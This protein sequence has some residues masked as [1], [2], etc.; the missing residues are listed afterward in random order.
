VTSHLGNPTTTLRLFIIS[1]TLSSPV[2]RERSMVAFY[3]SRTYKKF[4]AYELPY[5]IHYEIRGYE[6]YWQC[7]PLM[8]M[9]NWHRPCPLHASFIKRWKAMNIR[10]PFL[11]SQRNMARRSCVNFLRS[12]MR[13]CQDDVNFT[14]KP[15]FQGKHFRKPVNK[16]LQK[17]NAHSLFYQFFTFSTCHFWKDLLL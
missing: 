13:E 9:E 7:L 17:L 10:S 2:Q 11:G 16:G 3:F 8:W 6:K 1:Q 14:L 4:F 12:A 5:L 15:L